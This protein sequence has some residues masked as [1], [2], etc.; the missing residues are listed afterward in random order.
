M[1]K[2]TINI[3]DY[4]SA[5]SRL[6]MYSTNK[7]HMLKENILNFEDKIGLIAKEIN[8]DIQKT[9]HTNIFETVSELDIVKYENELNTL[10]FQY[11]TDNII[12]TNELE[13]EVS[14]LKS[15]EKVESDYFAKNNLII[16]KN[17]DLRPIKKLP[18][19]KQTIL[20]AAYKPDYL[21]LIKG[22]DNNDNYFA[23]SKIGNKLL[24]FHLAP[25]PK[26][27]NSIIIS[28]V[29]VFSISRYK[30][31]MSN[32]T[33]TFLNVIDDYGIT[34]SNTTRRFF[35]YIK[36]YNKNMKGD[37]NFIKTQTPNKAFDIQV[38]FQKTT[39]GGECS[40]AYGID[41]SLYESEN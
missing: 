11:T 10:F 5:F 25:D 16:K 27:R 8:K 4:I 34:I 14:L 35:Q 31:I 36:V 15:Y 20:K 17:Y 30:D 1:K 9:I 21:H 37:L 13:D 3:E 12:Q 22:S 2:K 26:L 41:T 32:P 24:V 39:Y 23:N 40:F 19:S 33:R 28:T 7:R 6:F 29:L 18:V 38:G